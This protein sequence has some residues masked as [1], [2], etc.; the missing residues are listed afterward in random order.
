[1]MLHQPLQCCHGSSLGTIWSRIHSVFL[2]LSAL[3]PARKEVLSAD[4]IHQTD[5]NDKTHHAQTKCSQCV[6]QLCWLRVGSSKQLIITFY[7]DLLKLSK[8][9][10]IYCS[11]CTA[12]AHLQA[13][14]IPVPTRTTWKI[15]LLQAHVLHEQKVPARENCNGAKAG[16]NTWKLFWLKNSKNHYQTLQQRSGRVS[17]LRVLHHEIGR[18]MRSILKP[19]R[20]LPE[21]KMCKATAFDNPNLVEL[22]AISIQTI[23]DHDPSQ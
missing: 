23:S 19:V 8:I 15:G 17:H 7:D 21:C 10:K 14:Q 16:R 3:W 4:A 20:E 12:T 2:V 22:N 9:T 1:M 6:P 5:P 13:A 11:T 18:K